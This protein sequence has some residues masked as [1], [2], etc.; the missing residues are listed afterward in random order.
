MDS[1]DRG[2]SCSK[3]E[4][5]FVISDGSEHGPAKCSALPDI[6][7]PFG[8]RCKT[9]VVWEKLEMSALEKSV[10]YAAV[11]EMLSVAPK[12]QLPFNGRLDFF[13]LHFFTHD[14]SCSD[15]ICFLRV[16]PF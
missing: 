10:V 14:L 1:I 6:E 12:H 13:F 3:K 5:S 11:F 16:A 15:G 9:R 4:V 7:A 2:V 8:G